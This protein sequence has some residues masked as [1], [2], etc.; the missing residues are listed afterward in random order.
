MKLKIYSHGILFGWLKR[1]DNLLEPGFELI[2]ANGMFGDDFRDL[3]AARK[4][5]ERRLEGHAIV[6]EQEV[7]DMRAGLAQKM[8]GFA[9]GMAEGQCRMSVQWNRGWSDP[10]LIYVYPIDTD[11]IDVDLLA[12]RPHQPNWYARLDGLALDIARETAQEI[13]LRAGFKERDM[14][15]PRRYVLEEVVKILQAAI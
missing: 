1:H 14:A 6:P 2:H 3:E 11:A 15:Y 9:E 5:L 13:N 4:F 7:R 10:D 8:S 12:G